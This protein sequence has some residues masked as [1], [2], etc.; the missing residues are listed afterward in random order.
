LKR[1]G[2]A[3]S[4]RITTPVFLPV[5]RVA[6]LPS[7]SGMEAIQN[8]TTASDF[9][10]QR[11]TESLDAPPITTAAGTSFEKNCPQTV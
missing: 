3:K 1:D 4:A 9:E 10:A 5:R 7:L 6:I 8:P 2:N 11:Q